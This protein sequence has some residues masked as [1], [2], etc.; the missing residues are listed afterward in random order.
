M[1]E[2]RHYDNEI[3]NRGYIYTNLQSISV[4][5][6]EYNPNIIKHLKAN[7][8]K[9][10]KPLGIESYYKSRA[11]YGDITS[12]FTPVFEAIANEYFG[13]KEGGKIKE[14]IK[15]VEVK[16]INLDID[17]YQQEFIADTAVD[18]KK[19]D[20]LEGKIDPDS[21]AKLSMA[22]DELA[23]LFDKVIKENLG[24]FKNVKRS[25]PA[26]RSAIYQWFNTYLESDKWAEPSLIT[27][28][29]LLNDSN[30]GV[31][32]HILSRATSEY[33]IVKQKEVKK[34]IEESEQRYSFDLPV[35]LFYNEHADEIVKSKKYAYD[36]SYLDINRSAPEK[37][38]EDY[39]N[40]NS[41]KIVWWWKN[42]EN[43]QDYFGIKY[44]YQKDIYTFYP[45][46]LAYL[47][48]RSLMLRYFRR[49]GWVTSR[50]FFR[51][52][53]ILWLS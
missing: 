23:V 47:S 15:A 10:Y 1:P 25:V 19:F 9:E 26:V 4:K 21:L 3:L 51:A 18:V 8:I 17:K 35:E 30:R 7:R 34:R 37:E 20:D 42:G 50:Y 31:F 14:N 33:A 13:I 40:Q 11:D 49:F 53:W 28:K 46:Y 12:T 27:Q 39:L 24:S 52:S 32:E 16:N 43:K 6:E 22:A 45:D 29:I 2:Q 48:R 44:E 41:S 38:F 36:P 5:K